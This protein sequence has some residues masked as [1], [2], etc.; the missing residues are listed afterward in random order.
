MPGPLPRRE[1]RVHLP[2]SSSEFIG[3][4][5][6]LIRSASRISP[7]NDFLAG[8]L[9]EAAD[10]PL[11]SGLPVCSPSGS[12]PP[13]P[14]YRQGS[15]GFYVRAEHGSL[16]SHAADMLAIRIQAIDG[17]RTST[18]QDSQLCRLLLVAGGL[19]LLPAV[20]HIQMGTMLGSIALTMAAGSPA[21]A[22]RFRQR[23]KDCDLGQAFDLAQQLAWVGST[24]KRSGHGP[25]DAVDSERWQIDS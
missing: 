2:V 16:P 19:P 20:T 13:L 21:G 24:R 1:P 23:S 15:Q 10:I 11:C 6:L 4:P 22:A 14:Y 12:F 8:P 17:A 9:F 25:S 3:L 5:Q 18:S 7:L